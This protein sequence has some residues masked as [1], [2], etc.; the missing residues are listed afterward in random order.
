M[1]HLKK[2]PD[3]AIREIETA[4][5]RAIRAV[6]ENYHALC[7]LPVRPAKMSLYR[8]GDATLETT[9]VPATSVFLSPNNPFLGDG[10]LNR[11]ALTYF[12]KGTDIAF[13][14]GHVY[15][16]SGNLCLGSIFVPSQVSIY[17]PA[18]PLETLFLHNDRNL[19]HGNA[20]LTV[21]KDQWMNIKELLYDRGYTLS[22]EVEN[23]FQPNESLLRR[24]TIWKLG[25][26]L[27]Q[28]Y[29]F[30]EVMRTMT[31]IYD[32][33]FNKNGGKK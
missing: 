22:P 31:L 3:A 26:E 6:M 1:R 16:G 7:N 9:V 13:P 32:I 11:D 10:I 12:V 27:L 20:E 19:S 21:N 5:A 24:D 17:N 18:Q 29:P 2:V 33:I 15:R 8:N 23:E 30:M 25:A 14:L 28:Q 4:H